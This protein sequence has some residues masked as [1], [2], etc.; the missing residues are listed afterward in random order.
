MDALVPQGGVAVGQRP[1]LPVG[2]QVDGAPDGGDVALE[3]PRLPAE[4]DD[5]QQ[6]IERALV[7][8][9]LLGDQAHPLG[10]QL[11]D[12]RSIT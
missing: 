3:V 1:A 9:A 12:E 11:G 7:P 8:D 10:F 2:R 6:P 5:A 4:G